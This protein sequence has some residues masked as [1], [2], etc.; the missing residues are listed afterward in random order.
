MSTIT[1]VKCVLYH[2]AFDSFCEKFHILEEV[3]LVLPNQGNTIHERH[4]GKIG[5]YTR[6][7]DFANFRLPVSTFLVD[8]LSHYTLDEETYPSFVDKDGEDMDIFAFIRTMDPTKVKVTERER[9]EDEPRLLETTVGRT[10][11][12]LLVV[13]DCGESELDVCNIPYFQVIYNTI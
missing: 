6:F 13:Y 7:F 5:L 12:L 1:D 2:R 3:H 11:P 10:V 9:R 8:I 4:I